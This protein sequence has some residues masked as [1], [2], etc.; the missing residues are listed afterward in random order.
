ML[1]KKIAFLLMLT[2]ALAWGQATKPGSK[3]AP[4]H[5]SATA[6]SAT[7]EKQGPAAGLPSRATVQSFLEH[8]F[9]WNPQMKIAIQEIK[10]SPAPGIA[11]IVVHA[12]TP[13]GNGDNSIFVPSGHHFAIAGQMVPFGGTPGQKPTN[14]QID[15]FMRKMT[16]SNPGITWT[17]AE[18]KPND[19]ANLTSVTVVLA[20][21]QGQR[22]A[23]RFWVTPDGGHAVL[24]DVS[25]FGADPFAAARAELTAAVTGPWTGSATP[26]I[27]MV[28]FGDLECPSC[29]AAAPVIERL[30]KEVPGSKLIFQ[31]FPL[32]SIHHWAYKAA[33]F[34][35]CV[36]EKNNDEFW[37]FAD[38]VFGAQEDISSHVE[39][40]DPNKK[41]DLAYAEQKLTQLATDAGMNGK[42]IAECAAT[43][44]ATDRVD[45][46]VELGKKMDVTGTPTL[47]VNGRKI[48]N[49]TGMPFDDLKKLVEF[50]GTAQGK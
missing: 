39:S 2:A 47:F 10:P 7:Q 38:L 41:P 18:I 16:G 17:V 13:K 50:A 34:S 19:V 37:K 26:K 25:P 4:A 20:N 43:K 45:H 8:V 3:S 49:I 6:K 35:T 11:E 30:V 42:Q 48:M 33:A 9:G 28:E 23:Q 1:M 44:Q 36:A 31:Q 27:T 22:G 12:E 21:P 15:D 14:E 29:K 40:A 32:T 5:S 46:S 24:G